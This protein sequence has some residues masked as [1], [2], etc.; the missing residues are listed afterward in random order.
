MVGKKGK[1]GTGNR[2]KRITR[3]PNKEKGVPLFPFSPFTLFPVPL[4]PCSPFTLLL[5][6]C[7]K[8][9]STTRSFL[10]SIRIL[11][12]FA[13]AKTITLPLQPSSGIQE[14]RFTIHVTWS[15]GDSSPARLIA[16]LN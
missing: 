5:F 15:T 11:P 14:C 3:Y 4:L 8:R 12:S 9:L 7:P 2:G 13:S 10:V 6:P 1:R 16:P